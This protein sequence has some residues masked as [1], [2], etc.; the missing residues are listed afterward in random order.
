MK[1][2]VINLDKSKDRLNNSIQISKNQKYDLIRIDAI[3]GKDLNLNNLNIPLLSKLFCPKNMIGSFL[4]H[5]KCW[6]YIIDNN[7]DDAIIL[8]DDFRID[9]GVDVINEINMIKPYIPSDMDVLLLGCLFCSDKIDPVSIIVSPF[10]G[11]DNKYG[12][13]NDHI[14]RP[15][16]FGGLFAYYVTNKGAKNLLKYVSNNIGGADAVLSKSKDINV[17]AVK[18]PIFKVEYTTACGSVNVES[19]KSI[20]DSLDNINMSLIGVPNVSFGWCLLNQV[21]RIGDNVV[22]IYH[23]IGLFIIF[24]IFLFILIC[25]RVIKCKKSKKK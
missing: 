24:I 3:Y 21:F 25:I 6:Q 15:I 1:A 20:I 19:N 11:Y 18:T 4:S 12:N 7:L 16:N 13:V 22:R 10:M 5:R 14:Y 2:L 9:D 17:Y 23:I 8:E